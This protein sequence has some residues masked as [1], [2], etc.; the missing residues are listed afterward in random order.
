MS[1]KEKQKFVRK[2]TDKSVRGKYVAT[3][4][5]RISMVVSSGTNPDLVAKKAQACG[6]KQ[7]VISYVPKGHPTCLVTQSK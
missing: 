4:T 2:I 7:P 1:V 5:I 3:R 6:V